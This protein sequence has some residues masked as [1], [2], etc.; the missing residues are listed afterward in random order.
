MRVVAR[1]FSKLSILVVILIVFLSCSQAAFAGTFQLKNIGALQTQG[2]LYNKW[3]YTGAQ[4]TFY[5]E[6]LAGEEVA[7]TADGESSTTT[8]NT[9]NEWSFTPAAPLSAGEHSL[10][11]SSAGSTIEFTLAIGTD[12]PEGI[13]APE[14]AS[15]PVAGG[16]L[17]TLLATSLGSFFLGASFLIRKKSLFGHF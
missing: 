16:I 2:V 11:F 8:V 12:I 14:A 4:P 9:N 13:T 17:P 1:F 10:S 6:G 3:Y 7:I 15:T 5:G